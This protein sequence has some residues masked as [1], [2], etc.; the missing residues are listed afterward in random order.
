MRIHDIRWR[1]ARSDCSPISIRNW[2]AGRGRRSI[3]YTHCSIL[4]RL[5]RDRSM[6]R[7]TRALD[8]GWGI[9]LGNYRIEK[10]ITYKSVI[11]LHIQM[12]RSLWPRIAGRSFGRRT[13][14]KAPFELRLSANIIRFIKKPWKL[15][16]QRQ[17]PQNWLYIRCCALGSHIQNLTCW[18]QHYFYM[19]LKIA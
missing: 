12:P 2:R 3:F 17:Q 10:V 6:A 18:S 13:R 7:S 19:P 1:C 14:S 11:R 5:T 8:R 15:A 4:I 9:L 16:R